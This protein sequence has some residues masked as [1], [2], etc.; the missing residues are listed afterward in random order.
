MF[1]RSRV[2]PRVRLGLLPA[3]GLLTLGLCTA[4]RAADAPLGKVVEP[5]LL[6]L[7]NETPGTE[8]SSFRPV[9]ADGPV[10][11]GQMLLGAPSATID[12]KS[13]VRLRL[14]AELEKRS[15]FPVIETAV[16]LKEPEKADA[17]FVLDRGRVLISN[18]KAEGEAVVDLHFQS[19]RWTLHLPKPGNKVAVVGYGRW[20]KGHI[21]TPKSAEKEQ[22]VYDFALAVI[23][24]E[25]VLDDGHDH[26]RL[27][28]APGNGL[29]QWQSGEGHGLVEHLK[30]VP[31]W[32]IPLDLDSTPEL[33]KAKAR[34]EKLRKLVMEKSPEEAFVSLLKSDDPNERRL[35]VYGL[36]AI[37]RLEPL[38][39]AVMTTKQEDVGDHAVLALRHWLGRGPGQAQRFYTM[40]TEKRGYSAA[41]AAILVQ[42]LH[43]FGDEDL[44]CPECYEMLIEYIK[45]DKQAI[46]GLAQWHLR[47]LVP[48][49]RDIHFDPAGPVED[50]DQAYKAW[51]KLIPDGK[52][53]PKVTVEKKE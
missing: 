36:A 33:R 50:R 13:G 29:F 27:H 37:D 30:K 10:F 1:N 53:P 18:Q 52:L 49:G 48:A 51:K 15:P 9:A 20:P 47:R 46:R 16:I 41:H 7:R 3:L 34:A 24:G 19:Q 26:T 4:A 23:E 12:L 42:L 21:F 11:A 28:A 31:D 8:K 43:S 40:L 45:H 39:D 2:A 35:G 6:L 22:P 38:G 25:A 14:L 5:T 32:G 44:A 17:S